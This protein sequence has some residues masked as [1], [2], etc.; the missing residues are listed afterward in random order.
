ML[1]ADSCLFPA[2]RAR[3]FQAQLP[4]P[5]GSW[6][7]PKLPR[8]RQSGRSGVCEPWFVV[9]SDGVR[10]C[11]WLKSMM[12]GR[13][14]YAPMDAEALEPVRDPEAGWASFGVDTGSARGA[15]KF[16]ADGAGAGGGGR[17]AVGDAAGTVCGCTRAAAEIQ[18]RGWRRWPA[19]GRR[20]MHGAAAG[21]RVH[22]LG[23][24]ACRRCCCTSGSRYGFRG[25]RRLRLRSRWLTALL[26]AMEELKVAAMTR[27]PAAFQGAGAGQGRAQAV[28]TGWGRDCWHCCA[29]GR[30]RQSTQGIRARHGEERL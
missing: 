30:I 24:A 7:R 9:G 28:S 19:A 8:R 23:R 26:Q 5:C 16:S 18:A 13:R 29:G 4:R 17:R 1:E 20:R 14:H 10:F 3:V 27:D 25:R 11:C 22:L 15:V 21:D 2:H 12:P 6:L